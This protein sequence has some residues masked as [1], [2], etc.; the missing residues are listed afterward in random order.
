M[1]FY[2]VQTVYSIPKHQKK[3]NQHFYN[4]KKHNL[5]FFMN[6]FPHRD[7]KL[8]PKG[9]GFFVPIMGHFVPIT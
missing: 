4:Y 5:V 1:F 9:R 2:T 7:Q 3:K 6:R 8:S